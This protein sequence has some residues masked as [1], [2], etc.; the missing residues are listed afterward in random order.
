MISLQF[1]FAKSWI[2]TVSTWLNMDESILEVSFASEFAL[3]RR[4]E[5]QNNLHNSRAEMKALK[6]RFSPLGIY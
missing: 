5:R 1:H 6:K 3:F 2:R 4:Q